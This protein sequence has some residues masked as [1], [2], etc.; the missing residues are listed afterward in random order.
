MCVRMTLCGNSFLDTGEGCDDG[1]LANSDGCSSGCEVEPG[2]KCILTN[3]GSS[4]CF[5][6]PPEAEEP[7]ELPPPNLR[8]FTRCGNAQLNPP[9]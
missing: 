4:A 9:E 2:W 1:N 3:A 8:A 5:P 6:V 7:E